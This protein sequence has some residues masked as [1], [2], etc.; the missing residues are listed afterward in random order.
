MT[1]PTESMQ[2]S[3]QAFDA[4]GYVALPG[5]LSAQ[6]VT[7]LCREIDRYI[8]E[9]VPRLP[10]TEVFYEVKGRPETLKQLQRI[11]HHDEWFARLFADSRFVGLAESLMGEA[12]I[13]KNL[14]WFNKPPGVGQPTPPHQDGYY[15][16][17]EPNAAVTMWLALDEVDEENGC[18]RYVPGS[19]R[20]GLRAHTRTDTLG[21]SQG[22][23]DYGIEDRRSE[24]AM[25]A[26]PGDLL[27]HHA[28]TVHR[29]DGNRSTNRTRRAL[30]FI[31]YGASARED[32]ERAA[33]YRRG[34]AARWEAEGKL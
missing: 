31:Y 23:P 34:L 11:F 26:K 10:P 3:K 4:N 13:G 9:V 19:Q 5:L 1:S 15:F 12:V 27:A 28:L 22:I 6:E 2:A 32:A 18:V 29:A 7:E 17:L 8:A 20:H 30:G 25:P 21:F 33:A 14:Q 16:M 24:V